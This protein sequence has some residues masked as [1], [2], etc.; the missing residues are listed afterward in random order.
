MSVRTDRVAGE[1]KAAV[2]HLFQNEFSDLADGLITVTNVR[3]AM[4]LRSGR[5]YLSMLGGSLKPVEVLKRIKE[6]APQLRS[7][8]ARQ[9]R[10]KFAPELFYYFDDTQEEVAKIEEIFRKI[11]EDRKSSGANDRTAE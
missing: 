2:A 3:M 11:S 5:V 10:L 8:V 7:G 9:V 4:D 6:V 1:V